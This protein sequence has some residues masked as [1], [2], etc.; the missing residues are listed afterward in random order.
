MYVQLDMFETSEVTLLRSELV[1]L[2]RSHEKVRKS[3]FSKYNDLLRKFEDLSLEY[4]RLRA[5]A[6]F[7]D[8]PLYSTSLDKVLDE[9][10]LKRAVPVPRVK[11]KSRTQSIDLSLFPLPTNPL[12]YDDK[13]VR[14]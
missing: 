2:R 13:F 4:D 6:S 7:Q 5:R 9:I 8:T 12:P 14:M 3:L 11:S 10:A 1:E